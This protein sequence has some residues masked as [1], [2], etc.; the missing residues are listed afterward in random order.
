MLCSLIKRYSFAILIRITLNRSY[1]V[2]RF[3]KSRETSG[4]QFVLFI[5]CIDK[6][7]VATE[8]FEQIRIELLSLCDNPSTS[9]SLE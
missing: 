3:E 4:S 8:I 1:M 2:F 5:L 9:S 7:T 6:H